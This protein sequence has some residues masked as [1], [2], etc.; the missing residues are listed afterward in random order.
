MRAYLLMSAPASIKKWTTSRL[1]TNWKPCAKVLIQCAHTCWC[2]HQLQSRSEQLP[3]C[4]QIESH[5]LRSWSNARILV[6]VCTSFHQEV[7]DFQ[8]AYKLKAMCWGL[9]P[10]RAY[11]LMSAPASIKKR[12]TSRLPT[13]WKPC[14]KVLIQCA[15]TCW[16]LH[17]LQSRSEQLPGCLQIESHVLRSWSNARILVDV[18]TSFH[19]EVNNFQVAY[20]LKAMC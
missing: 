18:C 6:D 4:L 11:L 14:A 8:V 13:N 20:K 5:V 2:L 15:H 9:G 19:Q 16:C 17:Q 12:T 3:G 1:P 7:N 10:M